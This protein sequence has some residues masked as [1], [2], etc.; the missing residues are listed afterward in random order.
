[1]TWFSHAP[2]R[3]QAPVQPTVDSIRYSLVRQLGYSG[4]I[5]LTP[6]QAKLLVKHLEPK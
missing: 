4:T 5:I 1:M 2:Q 3:K 6:E